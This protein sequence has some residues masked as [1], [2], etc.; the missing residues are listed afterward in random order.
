M[1]MPKSVVQNLLT[2]YQ[3]IENLSN[4]MDTLRDI[5][6]DLV[7]KFKDQIK[8]KYNALEADNP[9][10]FDSADEAIKK[11]MNEFNAFEIPTE[12]LNQLINVNDEVNQLWSD[13]HNQVSTEIQQVEVTTEKENT[14]ETEKFVSIEDKPEASDE[15]DQA[16]DI[17]SIAKILNVLKDNEEQFKSIIIESAKAALIEHEGYGVYKNLPFTHTKETIDKANETTEQL[18]SD[19]IK[20]LEAFEKLSGQGHWNQSSWLTLNYDSFN[21]NFTQKF[22]FNAFK[23][24]NINEE[25]EIFKAA[26]NINPKEITEKFA[27]DIFRQAE[28]NNTKESEEEV[29]FNQ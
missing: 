14:T 16:V 20:S 18:E 21:T 28:E 19:K 10:N 29:T 1:P 12:I 15:K 27:P 11:L 22:I 9:S 6:L 13:K 5:R 17:E 7:K 8:E 25:S 4:Q 23:A 26:K 2:Q 24:L 3:L